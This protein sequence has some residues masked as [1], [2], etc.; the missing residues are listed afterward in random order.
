MDLRHSESLNRYKAYCGVLRE[1]D[2]TT[3]IRGKA[4][5]GSCGSLS[6]GMLNPIDVVLEFL[7]VVP[8]QEKCATVLVKK[9]FGKWLASAVRRH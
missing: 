8:P 1:N 7:K 9:N 4:A 6:L 3:T 2:R 5:S